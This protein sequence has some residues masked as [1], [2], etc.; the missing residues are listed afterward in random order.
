MGDA[1][2]RPASE[3]SIG[4]ALNED[5]GRSVRAKGSLFASGRSGALSTTTWHMR[6]KAPEP[7]GSAGRVGCLIRPSTFNR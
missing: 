3:P 7:G 2:G 4:A 5:S 6:R 1:H